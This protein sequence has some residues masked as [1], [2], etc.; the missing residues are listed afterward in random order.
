VPTQTSAAE[1]KQGEQEEEEIPAEEHEMM[2]KL[3]KIQFGTWFEVTDGPKGVVQKV[4]L[5]WLSPLTSS[6]MFVDRAGV[7]TAIKPLRTLA[8][9]I[10]AGKSK[11]LDDSNNPFVERTLHA[12]RRMLQRSPKA[13]NEITDEIV[14]EPGKRQE[15]SS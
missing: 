1:I 10:L 3:R 12:I 14:S 5:S 13:N 6:C 2:E 9:E 8:Q 11:I 7:Q 15:E 4:K